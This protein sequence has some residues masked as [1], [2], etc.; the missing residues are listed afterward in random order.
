MDVDLL[1]EH[2]TELVTCASNGAPKRGAEMDDVGIIHDGAVAIHRGR[3]VAVG[4]TAHVR[5]RISKAKRV[6]EARGHSVIP[7]L[8]DPHTHVVW[9]GERAAEFEMRLKGATYLEIFQAGGGILRTVRDTREASLDDLIVQTRERLDRM[10]LA[11]TTTAEAKSGYGLDEETE[12]KM[13]DAIR[14]L[15]ESH[16]IDLIPTFLGAHAIPPEYRENPDA[17]VDFL[18]EHMIP[19]VAALQYRVET[20][21]EEGDVI[22]AGYER[23][24]WFCDVFCERG[25][26]NLEQT[27]RILEAA[28]AANMDLKVHVDEFEPSLGAVPVAVEMGA[29]SV[30]HLVSTPEEHLHVLAASDTAAVGLPGTPFGLA[31]CK[32]TKGRHLVDLGGIVAIASDINPGTSWCESMPM[33]MALATRYMGLTPAE[34]LNAATI[35]AAYAIKMHPYVGSIEEGKQGDVVILDVPDYRHLSYRYGGNLV[36]TVVKKGRVVVENHRLVIGQHQ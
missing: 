14:A 19:K 35:N 10:L 13:L 27:I 5:E 4:P 24:A 12:L 6:I 21:D 33:M 3:I 2:A 20:R 25:A 9:A 22:H 29:V 30:D 16:P 28:K 11:G 34:A 18:V 1:I 32:Y 23:A 8:V 7:G 36:H 17:Y 31:E 15:D 26:F